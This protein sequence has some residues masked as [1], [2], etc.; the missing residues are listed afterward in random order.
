M[1]A[2]N[3]FKFCKPLG[4]AKARHKITHRGK[5]GRGPGLEVLPNIL[6]FPFNICVTAEAGN[7]KFG[8]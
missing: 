8:M 5:S 6:V 2:A 3:D 4:F 1:A 7:F